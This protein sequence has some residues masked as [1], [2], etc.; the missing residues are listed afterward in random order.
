[1][2]E[3]KAKFRYYCIQEDRLKPCGPLL[4]KKGILICSSVEL[5]NLL[6]PVTPC[7]QKG[8]RNARPFQI[9]IL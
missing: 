8:V 3:G 7:R 5:K 1:M 6:L 4:Q 2:E 9:G